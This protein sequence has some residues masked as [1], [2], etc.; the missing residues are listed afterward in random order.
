MWR[1]HK[2]GI[3]NL[4]NTWVDVPVKQ[5]FS[6]MGSC[7]P[8]IRTSIKNGSVNYD[9]KDLSRNIAHLKSPHGYYIN[10]SISSQHR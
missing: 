3:R 4:L 9:N 1:Y 6:G 5:N 10:F 8:S 7:E 2:T